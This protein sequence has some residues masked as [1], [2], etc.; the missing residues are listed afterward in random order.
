MHFPKLTITRQSRRRGARRAAKS[1]EFTVTLLGHL[2]AD[3]L[4]ELGPG[5][6]ARRPVW[7]AYLGP[8]QACRAFTANFRAGRKAKT[9]LDTFEV[10]K[11]A[12]HRW[13]SQRHGDAVVTFAYLPEIFHL[14]PAGAPS[15]VAFVLL[16]PAWW[17][18]R[19]AE[20]LVGE[21]GEEA[22]EAARAALFVA[23]LS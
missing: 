16:P 6:K 23:G 19:Q 8:D 10:P 5:G 17:L 3:S 22:R 20:A 9:T 11:T 7:I 1:R 15:E 14:E 21:F 4:W 18:D 2:V 13:V 12:S